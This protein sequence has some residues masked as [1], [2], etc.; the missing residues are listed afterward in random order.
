MSTELANKQSNVPGSGMEVT[1]HTPAG[2]VKLNPMIVR[3]YLVNGDGPVTDQEIA[4]F[5]GLCKY[6]NLNPFL[7][8]AYLIKYGTQP[9]TIVTA[10][11]VFLKRA[12]RS[13]SFRGHKAGIICQVP[14]QTDLVHTE[15]I[16]PPGA[17]IVGGWAE[18]HKDGWPFP[19]RI[20]VDFAEY[21][22]K[23]KDGTV[24]RMW[25][26]KPATMIRKVA[27]VQALREAFPDTYQGMYSEEEVSG[28]DLPKE[29]IDPAFIV[30]V[31]SPPGEIDRTPESSL[32]AD[33]SPPPPQVSET[34]AS[35]GPAESQR[36]S[37][38]Y[39]FSVDKTV[40]GTD[41]LIT[42]G[43]T[44]EQLE[45][46]LSLTRKFPSAK[47]HVDKYLSG[48]GYKQ[49]SFLRGDEAEQ[50]LV[51]LR[52]VEVAASPPAPEPPSPQD[53]SPFIEPASSQQVPPD[54]LVTCP[55]RGG[56]RMSRSQYCESTCPDRRKSGWCP[57]LGESPPA[58]AA[59]L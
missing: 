38:R 29:T 4:L 15:G 6:Q 19:L 54:D 44:P 32:A 26:E 55:I 35:K 24:N 22:G 12:Y 49:M 31:T 41:E 51:T 13:E 18:V 23:K 21:V 52:P 7:R 37:R 8:E 20:E 47:S 48:I 58:S 5:L 1:I 11:E 16:C 28:E 56:D 34:A 57:I 17:K 53:D 42:C 33:P 9:A 25:G 10:K 59:M 43:S 14:E 3:R 45:E 36:R 30:D 2:D 40:F 46:L 27:L 50:L 39:K